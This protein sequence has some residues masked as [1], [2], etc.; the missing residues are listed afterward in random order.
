[1]ADFDQQKRQPEGGPWSH[2]VFGYLAAFL[3]PCA[4]VTAMALLVRGFPSFRFQGVL[5][6]LAVLVVA[7]NW[8]LGPSMLATFVGTVLLLFLPL[9]PLFSP[10]VLHPADVLGVCLSLGVGLTVSVLTSHMQRARRHADVL[11]REVTQRRQREQRTHTLLNT[12]L[13]M[14][15]I[16][17]QAPD[18]GK[19][20][21][22]Q[23]SLPTREVAEHLGALTRNVLDCQAAT[24]IALEP[25]NDRMSPVA[26][27]G[28][29]PHQ[30]RLFWT[31]IQ[32]SRL[33]ERLADPALFARL[34]A[35]RMLLLDLAQPP[36]CEQAHPSGGHPAHVVPM[37]LRGQLVGILT[38]H[39][40]EASPDYSAE[41]VA[42][43]E[44]VAEL[45]AL[46]VEREWLLHERAE[47]QAHVLAL[48]T[49]DPVTALPNHRALIARLDQ[50]LERAQQYHRFCS[51]LFLDLDHFKALNDGYGH[52]A[53]DAALS[54]FAGLLQTQL[55]GMD[56]V[57]RWGGEEFVA[58]LPER[59]A[60]EALHFAEEVRASVAARIFSVGG[61]LYLTCSIGVANYPTHAQEREGLLSAADQAMYG[62]KCFG[63]NQVRA[64]HDPAVHALRTAGQTE[65]G[66]AEAALMGMVEALATLVEVRDTATGHHAHQVADLVLQLALAMG[67]PVSEAQMLALAGRLHDVG[68]VSIPDA[69]LQKPSRLSAEEWGLVRTHPLVGADVVGHIPALRPLVPVIRAHH[70]RWDG[71]GYPDHLAG[72][73]IPFGARLLTAVDAYLTMTVDRPYQQARASSVALTELRRCAGSQFDPQVVAALEQV[74]LEDPLPGPVAHGRM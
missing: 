10:G 11:L 8:G 38:L 3:F 43:A 54:E 50:E 37:R 23:P 53:G 4:A 62:A 52:A 21:N 33:S 22:Q 47:A 9:S 42:L 57:G 66:R 51:L 28:F 46:V 5:V 74:L 2:P 61:G 63:R 17:V 56:T 24:I 13:T 60:D 14:T 35:G 34:Q 71:Q 70:E 45:A 16:L 67:L 69:V 25:H 30:E 32:G 68:K 44:A 29:S 26:S 12:L 1:M 73:A 55:R 49:T 65:G 72:E 41:E 7:L 20:G 15:E 39:L 6:M 31:T 58:I 59:N 19:A 40:R 48:A 64:A 36:W 27:I 18:P